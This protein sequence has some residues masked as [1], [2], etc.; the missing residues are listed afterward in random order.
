MHTEKVGPMADGHLTIEG[1]IQA[2]SATVQVRN[3]GPAADRLEATKSWPFYTLVRSLGPVSYSANTGSSHFFGFGEVFFVPA[4][5]PLKYSGLGGPY[6]HVSC[7]LDDGAFEALT[8]FPE[9]CDDNLLS[10]CRNIRAPQLNTALMRLAQETLTPSFA[11]ELF[12]DSL[13]NVVTVDLARY[14]R[15]GQGEALKAKGGLA[16]WQMRRIEEHVEESGDTALSIG[17]LAELCGVSS[18]HL[19]RAFKQTT[20][21]TVH[22]YVE[23]VRLAKAQRLLCETDLPLKAI[24]AELGFSTPSSFSFAFRRATGGTPAS[25]REQLHRAA[26]RTQRLK[27][28]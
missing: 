19:M 3:Y 9:R 22:A 11:S 7:Q 28:H 13:V 16:P 10:V 17:L 8:D 20:G 18:G 12:V 15:G 14:L 2:R 25:F 5:I 4:R 27:A 23:R 21:E 6:R 26:S 24:A 1:E